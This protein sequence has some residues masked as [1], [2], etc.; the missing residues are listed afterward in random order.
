MQSQKRLRATT[1]KKAARPKGK[2]SLKLVNKGLFRALPLS[3][4]VGQ[5]RSGF[6]KEMFM[7]HKYMQNFR[8]T[9]AAGA[10]GTFQI[11]CNA[12]FDP[13]NAGGTTHQP[14]YFDQ[15]A[16]L[17]NKYCVLAS[18]VTFTINPTTANSCLTNLVG[19]Y[20]EDDITITPTTA[21]GLAEQ[22]SAMFRILPGLNTPTNPPDFQVTNLISLKWD[23]KKAF[24]GDV[25]D[26]PN[27]T[28][29]VSANPTEQQY[30]TFFC[31]DGR[32]TPAGVCAFDVNA[33]VE[34]SAQY[35]ELK[36]VA[37]S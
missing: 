35:F 27:L 23:A 28:A 9:T 33:I 34:Y 7:R 21:V 6:P 3:R 5:Y 36:N 22:P 19:A 26:N 32:D 30:F 11:S 10:L 16:S 13:D 8:V 18:K 24:G 25:I 37:E 14:Y 4:N 17:Y 15:M 1:P 2:S 31:Q 12:L 29:D 20:I